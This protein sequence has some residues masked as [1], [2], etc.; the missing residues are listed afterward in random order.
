MSNSQQIPSATMVI[1]H[2]AVLD[3]VCLHL[4][5]TPIEHLFWIETGNATNG[6]PEHLTQIIYRI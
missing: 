3:F 6:E 4:M 5:M 1:E 2:H